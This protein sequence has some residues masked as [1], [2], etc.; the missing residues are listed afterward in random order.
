MYKFRAYYVWIIA[1][2]LVSIFSFLILR[3]NC[4][5]GSLVGVVYDIEYNTTTNGPA[6]HYTIVYFKDGRKHIFSGIP[7]DTIHLGKVNKISY[8]HNNEIIK[9]EYIHNNKDTL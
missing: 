4:E 3:L 2:I 7:C 6:Y 1:F 8:S 9:V 5:L